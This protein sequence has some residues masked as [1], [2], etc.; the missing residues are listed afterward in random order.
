M[1][2]YKARN[3]HSRKG[4][5]KKIVACLIQTNKEKSCCRGCCR[6][7]NKLETQGRKLDYLILNGCCRYINKLETQV[8]LRLQPY[9]LK[10]YSHVVSPCLGVTSFLGHAP[11]ARAAQLGHWLLTG[12]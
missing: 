6:Y 2:G 5:Y 8:E 4:L 11:F 10:W 3:R 12:T 9:H 1:T 7:T